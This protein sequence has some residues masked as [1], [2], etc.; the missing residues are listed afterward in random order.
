MRYLGLF[1]KVQEPPYALGHDKRHISRRIRRPRTSA[2]VWDAILV[3]PRS[4][5]ETPS[6][7]VAQSVKLLP[8]GK[9]LK[10]IICI[11]LM[12]ANEFLKRNYFRRHFR[13]KVIAKSMGQACRIVHPL[14]ITGNP[15]TSF[16]RI[17]GCPLAQIGHF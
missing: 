7:S 12:A 8:T 5:A 2:A 4:T 17:W 6:P 16:L 11:S 10:S 15:L 14:I 13:G 3:K 9:H 1:K